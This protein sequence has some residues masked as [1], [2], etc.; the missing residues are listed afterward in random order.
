MC[1]FADIHTPFLYRA[2]TVLQK[3]TVLNTTETS[4]GHS[5]KQQIVWNV[6]AF[7]DIIN[8]NIIDYRRDTDSWMD[9]LTT[10]PYDS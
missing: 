7:A 6:N 8:K 2:H 10:Y 4:Q 5:G 1:S 3:R 9:L